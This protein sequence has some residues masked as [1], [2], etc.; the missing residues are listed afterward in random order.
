MTRDQLI[1]RDAERLSHVQ[2][3][4]RE[5]VAAI[6]LAMDALTFPMTVTDALRTTDE[7][8]ALFA[9]GRTA[10][11]PRVTNADGVTTKSNHQSGR[12]VD[13]AFLDSK[14]QPTWDA[15]YPWDT[16]GACAKAVGLRWGG[17]FVSIKDKPH[18]ELP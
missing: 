15:A 3:A 4:L 6:L 10:P 5:K 14:N 2:P 17:D 11:G 12:A 8:I 1:T 9:K 16:Y 18:V 13:C 7:Q